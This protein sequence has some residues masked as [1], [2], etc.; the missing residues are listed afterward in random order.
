[1]IDFQ[2]RIDHAVKMALEQ[3]V[4]DTAV[5]ACQTVGLGWWTIHTTTTAYDL[6]VNV[7]STSC[8]KLAQHGMKFEI[9][10]RTIDAALLEQL[11]TEVTAWFTAIKEGGNV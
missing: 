2:A 10:G 5:I 11:H 8:T 9:E 7:A 6:W 1:M 4:R 3:L